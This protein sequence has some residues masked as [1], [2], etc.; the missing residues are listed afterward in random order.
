METAILPVP[1]A[2]K[3]RGGIRFGPLLAQLIAKER[4]AGARIANLSGVSPS[5]ITRIANGQMGCYLSVAEAIAKAVDV[6]L[7]KLKEGNMAVE[8]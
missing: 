2:K 7:E 1:P 6:P 4:G 8:N 5:T 3:R